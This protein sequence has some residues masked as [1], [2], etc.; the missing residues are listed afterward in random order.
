MQTSPLRL[1]PRLFFVVGLLLVL[2][3]SSSAQ[4]LRKL[5]P[6]QYPVFSDDLSYK[7]IQ[8]AAQNSLAYLD[9]LP[10]STTYQVGELTCSVED[11]ISTYKLFLH[12]LHEHP[13]AAQL[14][15]SIKRHFYVYQ[16][17][18]VSGMNPPMHML[19]TGYYQP[20]F[21]GSLSPTDEY[22]YPLYK[23]PED[24][25]IKMHE[26]ERRAGR[27]VNGG[28]VSY[29]SRHDIEKDNLLAGQELLW[30]KSPLDAFFLHVQ[31][32]GIV[33]FRDGTTR[34]VRYGGRN[35]REYKSIGKYMVEQGMIT[36][37]EASLESI[38]AYLA[39][40]PQQRDL[41]LHHNPSYIFF[42]WG[43]TEN[44]IGS[45]GQPLTPGRSVAADKKVFPPGSL[46]FLHTTIPKFED[47]NEVQ[48]LP[49][50]RFVT[51]QDTG[52]A[53]KGAGRVDLFWGTGDAAG[54]AA[55]MMKQKGEFYLLVKKAQGSHE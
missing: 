31:G 21:E 42:E 51:V 39:S 47:S 45:I 1:I 18:G 44:A 53:I 32:S 38:R 3:A 9:T 50:N 29:W 16:A 13:D 52:S 4:P 48:W 55:G 35:G 5:S 6:S 34:G 17:R 30:L 24:L 41:I 40:H 8:Q 7:E 37:E 43:P 14:N 20:V 2:G 11:L 54:K 36:L 15:A 22:A 10:P 46:A 12:C 25:V 49:L 23:V 27:L 19:V 28:F 26:G 33:E